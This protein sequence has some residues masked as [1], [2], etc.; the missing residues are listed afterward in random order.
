MFACDIA[1]SRDRH[2]SLT[3]TRTEAASS[4]TLKVTGSLWSPSQRTYGMGVF[5]YLYKEGLRWL[6]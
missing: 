4:T 1:L 6:A 5:S 3:S 2:L